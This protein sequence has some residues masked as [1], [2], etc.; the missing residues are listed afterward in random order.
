M[1]SLSFETSKRCKDIRWND[2]VV[3]V[4]VFP[5]RGLC[6]FL[7][8]AAFYTKLDDNEDGVEFLNESSV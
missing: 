7:K 6:F 1:W 2:L 4:L 8:A 5:I 3:S